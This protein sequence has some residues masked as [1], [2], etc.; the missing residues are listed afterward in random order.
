MKKLIFSV[1]LCL[2]FPLITYAEDSLKGDEELALMG[3]SGAAFRL[4]ARYLNGSGVEKDYEKAKYYLEMA[5]LKD[6]AHA[7]YD[8]G[9]MYLYGVGVEKDYL[10]AFDYFQRSTDF[11]FAPAYYIIG[12][13]YHDGA[14]VKQNEKKAYEYCK[15]A[16]EKGYKTDVIALDHKNK[17]IIILK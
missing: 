16:F 13:M 1:M 14:G 2:I 15:K 10:M 11:D 5:A 9:Y 17:K 12:I 7:L 6:H 4:G 3:N 8:L